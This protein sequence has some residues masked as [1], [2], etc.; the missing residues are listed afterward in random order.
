VNTSDQEVNIKIALAPALRSG[1]LV[2]A[3]RNALLAAMSDDVAA[4]VLRNNY[5]QS[6]ALSLAARRDAH[7][8]GA[9]GRLLR[10]L[11]ERG[12]MERRLEALPGD[13][14]LTEA[15]RLGRGLARP[16]LAVVLSYAKI[17][18]LQDLLASRAPDDP[19]MRGLLSD[20]FP[21]ALRDRFKDE[22]EGHR[23][24]REIVA[25]TL[26]NGLVNRLG[27]ATPLALADSTG[28]PV[29]EV[30]F[31]FMAARGTLGLA[32]LW[33]RLDSLDG[34]VSGAV[35]LELYERVRRVLVTATTDFLREGVAQR[36]LGETIEAYSA[37]F[38]AITGELTALLPA[39]LAQKLDADRERLTA[40][41]VPPDVADEIARL[42]VLVDVPSIV[43]TAL[44]A[45]VDVP[46][47]AEAF[48]AIAAALRVGEIV[49][50]AHELSPSDDYER[51]AISGGI[52][53]LGEAHRRLAVDRVVACRT[54][55]R[56]PV[57]EWLAALGPIAARAGSDLAAIA[58]ARE[59]SVSRLAVA[60]ARL[61]ALAEAA[62]KA[63]TSPHAPRAPAPAHFQP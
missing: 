48:L 2:V 36:P 54:G 14:E 13:H 34:V 55:D 23:L 43:A 62:T 49:A 37:G 22:I 56:R 1:R 58:A 59:M 53:S 46:A 15:A 31:A 47:A 32:A 16:A 33:Q 25:T 20:Y 41:G 52:A 17:A 11:E 42:D 63:A 40:C 44:R 61:T 4:A 30:A 45:Q 28:R 19:Y 57:T 6:L 5:Q 51:L 60:A 7:D 38:R 9:I 24:R 39:P 26:T 35:Q 8:I 3:E 18:V 50:R 12:L 10:D 21:P 29:T 27:P